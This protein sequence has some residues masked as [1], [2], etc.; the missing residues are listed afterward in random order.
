VKERCITDPAYEEVNN[1]YERAL[2]FMHKMPRIWM[3]YCELLVSQRLVTRTRRVLDRAL[4]AL[5]IT[6]H[7]RIW[8]IYITFVKVRKRIS[9]LSRF[10]SRAVLIL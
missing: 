8:P 6:Q 1:A 7:D 2:V 3:D 9:F 5:P 4:R 10:S